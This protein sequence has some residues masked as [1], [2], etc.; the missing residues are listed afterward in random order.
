MTKLSPSSDPLELR[1][2][3][4]ARGVALTLHERATLSGV[5]DVLVVQRLDGAYDVK[6]GSTIGSLVIDGRPVLIKP[7][8]GFER[9]LFLVSYAIDRGLWREEDAPFAKESLIVDAVASAFARATS[10]ALQRGLLEGYRATEDSLHTVRGRIRIADQLRTRL[11]L[12]PPIE[13]AFDEFTADIAENRVVKAA[14]YTLRRLGVR[15][16]HVSSSLRGLEARFEEVSLVDYRGVPVPQFVY[17]RLNGHY[18]TALSLARLILESSSYELKGGEVTAGAFTIDMNKA[19][20]DFVVIALREALGV[21]GSVLP[22]GVH[23]RLW[24]DTDRRVEL[25]PDLSWWSGPRCDFVGD[26]KY[27]RTD[28]D[29]ESADLYQLLAYVVASGL[30]EGLLIYAAGED[31]ATTHTVSLLGARLHVKALELTGGPDEI[32]AEIDSLAG[33]VRAMRRRSLR[34]VAVA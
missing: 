11:G 22:Q 25:L 12:V 5:R 26:V 9:A 15:S 13:V 24:L 28:L 19:F 29:G 1:E 34:Q 32:L 16:A 14:L 8:I 33:T 6:P 27:K 4:W 7:K 30:D 10:R 31:E 21:S 18:R 2:H 23:G 17:T 20:E 3:R